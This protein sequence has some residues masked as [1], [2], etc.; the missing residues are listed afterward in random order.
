MGNFVPIK[1]KI[2]R[3][4]TKFPLKIMLLLCMFWLSAQAQVTTVKAS[5]IQSN[6]P[7][8]TSNIV[9]LN[10]AVDTGATYLDTYAR[11]NSVGNLLNPNVSTNNRFIEIAFAEDIPAN[12]PVYLKMASDPESRVL[13]V[14]AGGA[15]GNLLTTLIN[16]VAVG[17]QT[18]TLEGITAGGTSVYTNSSL[19]T[20]NFRVVFNSAGQYFVKITHNAAYR[21]I[22]ITNHAVAGTLDVS[23]RLDVYGAYFQKGTPT[24]SNAVYT[25]YNA[26]GLLSVVDLNITDAPKAIDADASTHSSL[27]LG[28]LGAGEWIEQTVYF[29]GASSASDTYNIK[30]AIPPGLLAANLI[31][32][33]TIH[34]YNGTSTTPAY[35]TD[36]GTLL[37]LPANAQVLS[38]FTNNQP[39]TFSITPGVA[40]NR[41]AIRYQALVAVNTQYNLSIY[42]VSKGFGL[43]V[44][45]GGTFHVNDAVNLVSAITSSQCNP[46]YTY[47]WTLN[48]GTT[49]LSTSANYA[50]PTNT[51]GTYNYTLAVTDNFGAVKTATAQVIVQAPPVAGT[52]NNILIQCTDGPEVNLT[53][54]GY[55]GSVLRWER[56]DNAA[57]T[58]AT[59]LNITTPYLTPVQMG[60]ITQTTYF[61]AF[62]N[63]NNYAE[64]HTDIA[65]GGVV[66]IKSS[67]W[68][69]S[70]WSNGIPDIGTIIYI[71][72]NYSE[73][74]DLTGCK[75]IVG[76]NAV[77]TIPSDNTVHLS[78]SIRVNSGSFTLENEAHLIQDTNIEANVG[79][80]IVTRN[81][82]SLFR[83]DYTLWSAPVAGQNLKNFSPQTHNDRFY[84]YAY[85][86]ASNNEFYVAL[87]PIANSF[88]AAKGYLIRMPNLNSTPGY[89]DGN[90]SIVFTGQFTGVPNNGTITRTLSTDGNRFT[91]VGN[92]FPSPINVHAF[93]EANASV[94]REGSALYFWRK[95]NN[96]NASSYATMTTDVYCYN[97]AI[98]GNVG[99]EQYGGIQWDSHFNDADPATWTINTGQGFIVRAKAELAAGSNPQLTFNAGMR[100]GNVHTN[101]FFRTMQNQDTP[102]VNSRI[103]IEMHGA[104]EIA[105]SAL[106]YSSTATAGIDYGRDAEAM[107][108][109]NT[110]LWSKLD[111][112]NL[113]IQARPQFTNADVVPMGYRVT[114]AGQYSLTV[115]R[116]DGLFAGDQDI[117]IKD[118]LLGTVTSIKN[119][120]YTFTTDAGVFNT[121]FEVVYA[122]Q[123]QLGTSQPSLD[124]MVMV[125][126]NNGA[127]NI[128]AG[129][130]QINAVA[131]YDIGGRKLYEKTNINNT[132]TAITNL[133]AAQQV[134]LV[135]INTVSGKVTK[136]IIY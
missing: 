32:G 114:A 69:G 96:S 2:V 13:D 36:M 99:E 130:L 40:V 28:V 79:N 116:A 11:I 124:N 30:L 39:A 57:F 41:I 90:T 58:N 55:Q 87:D 43:S 59:T 17:N 35:S 7:V 53:L 72:G 113:V 51:P 45:G 52:L 109:G 4:R 12:T 88:Q 97:H 46:T 84:E 48:G 89:N 93:F 49:V 100:R 102:D 80:I 101:Q 25:S 9:N 76:N 44:T 68:N 34:T 20:E 136:K 47:A 54:S 111:S 92:P 125:Y 21:R 105:Q 56:A 61:R 126:Q 134:L 133:N 70:A 3:M 103:W 78:K 66:S 1:T 62:V 86:A 128:T 94:L 37:G 110:G 42:E 27:T 112:Y 104:D 91:L 33:I 23:K 8:G 29:E 106:V 108:G 18:I 24:C 63:Q 132:E 74:T 6:S 95:K 107:S 119:N 19:N 122:P 77:V 31:G 129:T 75:I 73:D 67:E 83:L 131:V 123:G 115:H 71:N 14:L 121:R 60:S 26:G 117:Y 98:G 65:V 10:D 38:L 81:S 50:P 127:I 15:I 5:L 85:V 22:K 118:N 120:T 16:T 64:V 82:S 135:E